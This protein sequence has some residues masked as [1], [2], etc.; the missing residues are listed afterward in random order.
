MVDF[1]RYKQLKV[2]NKEYYI[3][4]YFITFKG[5]KYVSLLSLLSLFVLLHFIYVFLCCLVGAIV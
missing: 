3:F 5:I 1:R 4:L 2:F